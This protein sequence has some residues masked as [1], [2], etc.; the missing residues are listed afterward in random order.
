MEYLTSL[1][2]IIKDSFMSRNYYTV[3]HGDCQFSN[4]LY[5]AET[6]TIKFIDPRG[7]FGSTKIFGIAEYDFSK[8]LY[9]LSGYDKF[10]NNNLFLNID[11]KNI[12]ISIESCLDTYKE[13]FM[14]LNLKTLLAMMIIHW[15]GIAQ[16]IKHDAAKSIT[17][18]YYA[19]SIS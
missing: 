3:I 17:A 19:I 15:F 4:T 18:Y 7:Y 2:E 16:Y 6:D 14:H 1:Y 13:H 5:N 12:T 8:I 10:N 11:N 9:A